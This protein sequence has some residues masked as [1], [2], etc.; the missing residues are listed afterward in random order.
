M[1]S[2]GS[3]KDNY[4]VKKVK[5]KISNS[6]Y[7]L[8]KSFECFSERRKTKLKLYIVHTDTRY[9][10]F[11]SWTT[12]AHKVRA[13]NGRHYQKPTTQYQFS[14]EMLAIVG[15]GNV[16]MELKSVCD[17]DAGTCILF[18]QAGK[19][20]SCY[21]GARNRCNSLNWPEL[22]NWPVIVHNRN[23]ATNWSLVKE[24]FK[25]WPNFCVSMFNIFL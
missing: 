5:K 24:I 21:C 11:F 16:L 22:H 15:A 19:D 14:R 9:K 6:K 4:T 25:N 2:T 3:Y 7:L 23:L 13:S 18:L 12:H 17:F 20:F 8:R 10:V 1:F